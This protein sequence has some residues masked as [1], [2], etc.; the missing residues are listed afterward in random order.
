V[1]LAYRGTDRITVVL[2]DRLLELVQV[3]RYRFLQQL[4]LLL[5]LLAEILLGAILKDD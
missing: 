2:G 3:K 4:R 1:V 5:L